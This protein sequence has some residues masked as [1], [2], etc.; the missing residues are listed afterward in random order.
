MYPFTK[1][2]F[3]TLHWGQLSFGVKAYKTS[4]VVNYHERRTSEEKYSMVKLCRMNGMTIMLKK[5]WIM[6]HLLVTMYREKEKPLS[7][8][9][10]LLA[11]CIPMMM[12]S[13]SLFP[14]RIPQHCIIILKRFVSP[15]YLPR[16]DD[17]I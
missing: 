6:M 17:C 12:G 4:V 10:H 13:N 2:I 1:Q 5:V 7:F 14:R 9:R 11:M 15:Y 16:H 8:H 3:R